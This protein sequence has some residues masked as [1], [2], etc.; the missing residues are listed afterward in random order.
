MYHLHNNIRSVAD[1][2]ETAAAN[3]ARDQLRYIK[4]L[5]QYY[6]L[7][8]VLEKGTSAWLELYAA[9]YNTRAS[10]EKRL[11][12]ENFGSGTGTVSLHRY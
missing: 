11:R 7:E 8:N 10:Q 9:S 1:Q 6:N 2:S 12:H 4:P 5:R 3:A